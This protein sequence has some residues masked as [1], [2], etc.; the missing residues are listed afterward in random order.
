MVVSKHKIHT[1]ISH[2]IIRNAFELGR[3]VGI[4]FGYRLD[5]QGVRV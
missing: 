2:R 5:D 1:N 4:A 3:V